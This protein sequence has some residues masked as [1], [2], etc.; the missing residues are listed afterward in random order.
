MA[1][2]IPV[3]PSVY[4][5]RINSLSTSDKLHQFKPLRTALHVQIF[6]FTDASHVI[7]YDQAIYPRRCILVL[8]IKIQ[9]TDLTKSRIRSKD[10]ATLAHCPSMLFVS[11]PYSPDP[12]KT[13]TVHPV[14]TM[15]RHTLIVLFDI[16]VILAVVLVTCALTTA[17]LSKS[18]QRSISWYNFMFQWL[19]ISL[20]FALLFGQQEGAEP[21][22]AFCTFQALLVHAAPVV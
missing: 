6:Q 3:P 15:E 11:P 2:Y 4:P 10:N 8:S 7:V 12:F 13:G 17:I 22:F 20:S 19:V 16:L 9:E 14:I 5:T 1:Y 21:P 18:I